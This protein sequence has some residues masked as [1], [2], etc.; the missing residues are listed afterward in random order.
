MFLSARD[1]NDFREFLR[2]NIYEKSQS[3]RVRR[4]GNLFHARLLKVRNFVCESL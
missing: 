2:E 4:I 1:E 3:A